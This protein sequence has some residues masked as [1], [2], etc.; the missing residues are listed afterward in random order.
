MWINQPRSSRTMAPRLQGDLPCL[1]RLVTH[2]SSALSLLLLFASVGALVFFNQPAPAS[3]AGNAAAKKTPNP[4]PT[5]TATTPP[6][7]P[8]FTP[9]PCPSC[10]GGLPTHLLTGYWQDFTNS[11]TPL[12]LRA[13]NPYYTIVAI[14][15]ASS[16]SQAGQI[17]FS[18]DAKLASAR[19]ISRRVRM[20]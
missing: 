9:T 6:P 10:Q 17:T 16:G 13:V 14:A 15:F 2:S 11:A 3:A 12:P 1:V 18:I 20:D 19:P 4:T 8:S 7:T 5:V